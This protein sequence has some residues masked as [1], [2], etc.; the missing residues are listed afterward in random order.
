[1]KILKTVLVALIVTAAITVQAQKIKVTKGDLGFLKGQTELLL[2]YDYSNMAVGKFDNEQ[3]YIAKKVAEYNEKEAGKGDE[4]AENWVADREGRFH[5]KFEELANRYTGKVSCNLDQTNVNAKYTAIIKVTFTEPGFN[6]GVVRKDAMINLEISFVE[7]ANPDD[8][9]AIMTMT[10]V[11]GR[12]AMGNDY[13]TGYRISEAYAKGGKE[14]GAY[15][16]K[17]AFK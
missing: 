4:W 8:V 14:F 11:P 9:L 12:D 15:L 2:E 1:M 17:K 7:T 5:P 10:N 6:V 16:V 13:D 3:D